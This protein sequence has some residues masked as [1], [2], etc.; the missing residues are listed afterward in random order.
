MEEIPAEQIRVAAPVNAHS[1]AFHRILRGRTHAAPAGAAGAGDFW[2]WREQMYEA[3]ATLTPEGYEELATA[4]FAEMVVSGFSAVG[5][6]H[7]LHHRPDGRPY[8][9]HQMERALARAALTARIRLTLLDTCYLS[10]G[11]DQQGRPLPLN[12]TQRRFSDGSAEAWIQRWE[13]LATALADED[14]G[15]GLVSLGAALH[16]L[17]AVPESELTLL[18]E[19]SSTHPDTPL[20]V[21]LSEQPAEN[22]AV[23]AAY[24]ASP[25]EV[26]HRHGL[27]GPQLSAVHA[28]HLSQTDIELLGSSGTTIV[29]CPTT[30]ADLADGIGPARELADAGATISLGTDQHAVVDPYLEMRALEHGERL[31]SGTRGRFSPAEISAAA[32]DGGLRSLGLP[33]NEDYLLVS[34]SSMRTAGSRPDQLPLS[35]TAQDV[36]AVVINGAEVARKG[37]HTRLGDPAELYRRFLARHRL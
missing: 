18:A 34:T 5:E 20:H 36:E 13:S 25:T 33:P 2:V 28:T 7:Y 24:G 4:V 6:F 30:E 37:R 23:Q 16:S 9:D 11:L 12:Q 26:L 14:H 3:A 27:L 1:H 21:H 29:M 15:T 35:A 22:S 32:R 8:P 19:W 10:G 17:R 31:R